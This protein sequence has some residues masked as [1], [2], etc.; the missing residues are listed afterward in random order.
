MPIQSN[1]ISNYVEGNSCSIFGAWFFSL[2]SSFSMNFYIKKQS[3]TAFICFSWWLGLCLYIW[4]IGRAYKKV[5]RVR[6]I[7]QESQ[8]L[9]IHKE[10]YLHLRPQRNNFE[11]TY[12]FAAY[13][14]LCPSLG[15]LDNFG[16]DKRILMTYDHYD[17]AFRRNLGCWI[18]FFVLHFLLVQPR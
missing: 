15:M 3:P 11:S 12:T 4:S 9:S 14:I 6:C 7:M 1:V 2:W 17:C 10:S 8:F 5:S 18:Y 16:E 13:F